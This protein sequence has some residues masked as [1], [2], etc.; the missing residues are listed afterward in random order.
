MNIFISKITI[1]VNIIVSPVCI[2]PVIITE[3]KKA[4]GNIEGKVYRD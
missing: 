3:E 4:R 2:Y 1:R